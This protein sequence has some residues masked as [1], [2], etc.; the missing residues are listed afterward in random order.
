MPAR[1]TRF[2]PNWMYSAAELE[3]VSSSCGA[4]RHRSLTRPAAA[5]QRWVATSLV[6]LIATSAQGQVPQSENMGLS[7]QIQWNGNRIVSRILPEPDFVSFFIRLP[8]AH[9]AAT[10]RGVHV[11]EVSRGGAAIIKANVLRIAPDSKVTRYSAEGA[12]DNAAELAGRVKHDGSHLVVIPDVSSWRQETAISFVGQLLGAGIAVFVPSDLA[13]N[14]AQIETINKLH[15][16]GAVTVGRVDRQSMVMKEGDSEGVYR[17]FNHRIRRIETDVFSTIGID[18]ATDESL[19]VATAAGVAALVLEKWPGLSPTELRE[20]IVC[21]ARRVWQ[22]TSIETGTWHGGAFS[23]DPVTTE[24]RP[25]KEKVIFR[26]RVL[27]AAGSLD[28]DTE[29]PWFLNMLNCQE[30]WKVTK[31]KGAVVAVS[32]HGFHLRHPDLQG[33]IRDT[34]EFGP[35]SLDSGHQNFHGTDMSRIVLA[36]APEAT[37]IP[38]LCSAKAGGDRNRFVGSLAENVAKSFRFATDKGVDA[39]TASWMQSLNTNTALLD[40]IQTAVDRGVTVSW[41]HYPRDEPG[42]LRPSFVYL[43]LPKARQ[44]IGFADRFLLNPPG[45]HPVE[46]E[47]GLSGTAPQAAGLAALARSVNPKLTPRQ[48]EALIFENST[49]IGRGILIPDAY[50]IVSAA[51]RAPLD[52]RP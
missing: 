19:A 7:T 12:E 43:R 48:I 34:A 24:Y 9:A 23:V 18:R 5:S 31:G 32:D 8:I 42:V 6:V 22:V 13:K 44:V 35:A 17:P 15:S 16:L 28:V 14:E 47:A 46:I 4:R 33:R 25:A 37:L 49:P 10:G 41:F 38:V 26:F 21:G 11:S 36:V 1:Q 40:S 30:A 50:A 45:F 51:A 27:D 39:I 20:R 52:S 29:I 3:T 2:S